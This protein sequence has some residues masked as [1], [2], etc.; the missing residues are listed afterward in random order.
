MAHEKVLK[1]VEVNGVTVKLLKRWTHYVITRSDSTEST[2]SFIHDAA[3]GCFDME[4]E[5]IAATAPDAKFSEVVCS[6]SASINFARGF[7]YYVSGCGKII[8]GTFTWYYFDIDTMTARRKNGD[9]VARF[10]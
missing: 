7:K 1:E 9:V 2:V 3:V 10:R 6:S 4:I 5:S 8:V